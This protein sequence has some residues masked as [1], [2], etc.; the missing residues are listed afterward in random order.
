M[1]FDLVETALVLILHL[2]EQDIDS[3]EAHPSSLV[4]AL[5]DRHLQTVFETPERVGRDGNRVA[6]SGGLVP[7]SGLSQSRPGYGC[8]GGCG[9]PG[10]EH[11][12]IHCVHGICPFH[13]IAD[14]RLC[15]P[16]WARGI[17]DQILRPDKGAG[18]HLGRQLIE[19]RQGVVEE[20]AIAFTEITRT[21][22]IVLVKRRP[23]LHATTAA[24]RQ[25]AAD[26]TLVAEILFLTAKA[27]LRILAASFSI[28]V[29]QILPR[30]HCGSTKKSHG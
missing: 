17:L 29:S 19:A 15:R 9:G 1:V 14:C 2:D 3:I 4:D 21:T 27:F 26:Q 20:P 30:Y 23:V 12:S 8:S 10:Q 25:V 5:G 11:S 22:M 6:A 24:D 16:R 7:V 28:G 13:P 18:S